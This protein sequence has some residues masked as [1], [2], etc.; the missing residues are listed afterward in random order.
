MKRNKNTLLFAIVACVIGVV[1]VVGLFT[2]DR[3][4]RKVAEPDSRL[5]ESMSYLNGIDEIA[6]F[7]LHGNNVYIG[8]RTVP[9]DVDGIVKGAALKG[10]RTI[11]SGFH[12]WAIPAGNRNFNPSRDSFYKETTARY[13]K[14]E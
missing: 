13:G 2:T 5:T 10:H 12:A 1:M 4:T 3:M 14:I 9:D 6:W 7:S 11:G 8:F